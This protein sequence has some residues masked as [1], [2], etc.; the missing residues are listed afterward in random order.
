MHENFP[1]TMIGHFVNERKQFLLNQIDKNVKGA[2][3]RCAFPDRNE[4]YINKIHGN[5][6]AT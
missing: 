1:G 2:L 3:V 5:V 4:F 6:S